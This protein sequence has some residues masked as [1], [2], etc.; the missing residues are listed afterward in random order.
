M[1]G[2]MHRILHAAM[3]MM[4]LTGCAS[5]AL[6]RSPGKV[7]VR[8]ELYFGMTRPVG[9]DVTDAEFEAFM[10]EIVAPRFPA[11]HTV[12]LAQGRWREETGVSRKEPTRVL[13]ILHPADEASNRMIE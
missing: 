12:M 7:M 6:M 1:L 3:V 10:E 11:G 9:A 13:V 4:L 8:T 2:R 5:P